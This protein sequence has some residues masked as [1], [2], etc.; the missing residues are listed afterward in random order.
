M[1]F[2]R[3]AFAA[4][5][6]ACLMAC[7]SASAIAAKGGNGTSSGTAPSITLNGISSFGSTVSFTVAYSAMKWVPEVSLSCSENG[8]RVYLVAQTP[9]GS[10]VWTPQFTLW[11]QNWADLGGGSANC[12]ANLY[13][14]TWQ[15]QTETGVVYLAQTSFVT[16]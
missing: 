10:G 9:S 14:Y 5:L 7:T 12:T 3:I 8:Q 4:L 6:S 2:R 13:Y 16:P 11:S 15:G 1:I